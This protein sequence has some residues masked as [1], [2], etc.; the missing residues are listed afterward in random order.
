VQVST[1]D[2]AGAQLTL[3]H[4]VTLQPANPQTWLALASFDE[5]ARADPRAA[6][7]DLKPAI[8][9]DPTSAQAD[10]EYVY[11]LRQVQ[12]HAAITGVTPAVTVN[13]SRVAGAG[14]G[15]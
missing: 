7:A 1:H 14:G 11:A 2:V 15:R 6:L 3:A 8:Y 13:P 5:T 4:A 9:L 12:P 10:G